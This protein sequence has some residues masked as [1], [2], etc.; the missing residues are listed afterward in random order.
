MILKVKYLFVLLLLFSFSFLFG[1]TGEIKGV[2]TD[3]K[4]RETIIG[5]NVSIKGTTRGVSTN[6]DGYFE[7]KGLTPGNYQIEVSFIS[8]KKRSFDVKVPTG[9]AVTLNV[10]LEEEIA[11]L[12]GVTITETR[13]KDSEISVMSAIRNSNLVINGVSR[14][15]IARS[16]DRDASEVIRRV[17]G[18]TLVE[19]R[20]VMVRGLSERYNEVWLNN[21]VTP[22][23]EADVKAFSFDAIP[24]GMI[25]NILVF[26]TPAPE[27]PAS[28]AGAAIQVYTR[29]NPDKNSTSLSYSASYRENTTFKNFEKFKGGGLDFLGFDDGTRSLPSN[30]PTHL[31]TLNDFNDPQYLANQQK[32]VSLSREMNKLWTTSSSTAIPDQRFSFDLQRKIPLRNGYLSNIT[33][34]S[35]TNTSATRT[36]YRN[37]YQVY[38]IANDKSSPNFLF[39][40]QEYTATAKISLLHNWSWRINDYNTIEFRNLFNQIGQSRAIL[41]E[42]TEYYSGQDIKSMENGYLS[43][44]TYSGQFG[45]K[46]LFSKSDDRLEW[47][48]GFSYG[49][50]HEPDVKRLTFIKQTNDPTSPYYGSYGLGLNYT[51]S[52][53]YAGRVF[54]DLNEYIVMGGSNYD[55]KFTLWGDEIDFKGG[56]YGEYKKRSFDTRLLGYKIA[57]SSQ[58]DPTLLFKP[59]D[60]IFSDENIN[61]N[62]GIILDE[63][64][65]PSDSYK[66][67]NLTGAGF[68]AL[69]IP[70][71]SLF[72][73]YAGVRVEFNN[74]KLDGYNSDNPTIPVNL[75]NS[76]TGLFPSA[77]LTYSIN[78]KSLLRLAYGRTINRPEFREIAPFV[79]YNFEYNAAF[80]GNPDLETSHIDNLDLRYEFYPSPF[81]MLTIGVFYKNFDKPIE[82]KYIESGSGL[83]YGFQNATSAR[84]LG[85]ELELRKSLLPLAET[86]FSF[87]KD[88][89]LVTNLSFIDSKVKFPKGGL[90]RDRPMQGQSPY[91]VNAGI[92]YQNDKSG[93]GMSLLYNVIGKR[94][95]VVGQ[96]Y[97]NPDEDI[98]DVYEMPRNSLDFTFTWK[99]GE[100]WTIKGGI[101][102]I[103]SQD[104]VFKQTVS[105]S[106]DMDGDGIKETKLERDQETLRFNPGR[107]I[108]L[109]LSYN[110]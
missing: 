36:K 27:L 10:E 108:T 96:P 64:T 62:S 58:F 76:E 89:V 37:N 109:G 44:A 103:I 107:Y 3:K 5:A 35:Y 87:L 73:L 15:Q 93:L 98:P 80:S 46:H 81:D 12:Q 104:V 26:K 70:F 20:F 77:N 22:S 40:D 28:F 33:S 92:Y 49:N 97:Q 71:G 30:F 85:A 55:H 79:F 24:G 90:E 1:Q 4:S 82:V 29:N 88:F 83:Q 63:T 86:S 39:E 72:N 9:K 54:M 69:K 110:F 102:D 45:G 51:A 8:Y 75:N 74:Q 11:S 66:A 14:E 16:Q 18:I 50:R 78:E 52:P 48:L 61:L 94:V 34:L 91:I 57:N 105:F 101:Q 23:S 6:L 65:N 56:I 59:V 53:K 31:N 38:D 95:S 43:R 21:S 60:E 2:V 47:N 19:G 17:P 25:D 68:A 67:S 99:R 13:K 100:H 106:K 84:S 42:G 7:I 32:L 41:R